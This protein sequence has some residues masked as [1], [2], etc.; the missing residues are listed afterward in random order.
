MQKG[1]LAKNL[2]SYLIEKNCHYH[3]KPID[4]NNE[5]IDIK[6]VIIIKISWM[7]G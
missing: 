5:I 1:G 7:R 2:H 4:R 6:F 3:Q